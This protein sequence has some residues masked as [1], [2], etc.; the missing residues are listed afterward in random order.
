MALFFCA[1]HVGYSTLVVFTTVVDYRPIVKNL[2]K[3]QIEKRA[4]E[5]LTAWLGTQTR[6]NEVERDDVAR[7]EPC[8]ICGVVFMSWG[9]NAQ[10]I[11][12]GRCCDECNG[13][14]V[15]RRLSDIQANARRTQRRASDW[16]PIRQAGCHARFS[17]G[18][19]GATRL[20]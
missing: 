3:K 10:P 8:S 1:T 17:G 7:T 9:N 5:N 6:E 20:N 18:A 4:Q 12:D 13:L 16:Q 2:L 19:S 15:A 14:V 11:N